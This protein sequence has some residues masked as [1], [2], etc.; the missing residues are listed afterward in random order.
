MIENFKENIITKDIFDEVERKDPYYTGRWK[1]Y[2]E[3]IDILKELDDVHNVLEFGPYILP[4]VRGSDIMDLT[5][6]NKKKYPFEIGKFMVH[7][8]AAV[9][10]P[11]KDKEYDL[12]IACQVME[13]FGMKGQQV[14]FF[15][16]LE[17]ICKKAIISLPY[18]W[19]RPF[20]RDHHMIDKNVI[21][22]WSNNRKPVFEM[23]TGENPRNLRIIQIYDFENESS[24]SNVEKISFK[25][26]VY[27]S[28]KKDD[29]I[30]KLSE[31]NEKLKDNKLKLSEEND[32]LKDNGIRLS[33]ENAMLKED[34]QTLSEENEKLKDDE[35]KLSEENKVLKDNKIKLS[36]ENAV[37]K[38]YKVRLSE[39]N[40][41]LK[42]NKIKLSEENA[43]LNDY[44]VRLSEE[45][46][47]LKYNRIKL[48]EEN[49]ALNDHKLRLSEENKVL[50]DNK[51]KLSEENA[52]L[53][54]KKQILSEENAI[55]KEDKEML[56]NEK[57]QIIDEISIMKSSKSWKVT[58]PLRV[59]KSKFK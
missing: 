2:S 54:N 29:L 32:R 10:L 44:K 14:R 52:K 22:Y 18:K 11:I 4:F 28:K 42:D 49:A 48:Y 57:M 26:Y 35:L 12:V 45:N 41:V 9:P 56:K 34:N 19:F 7:N 40:K 50:K 21:K 5:D 27:E 30:K 47:D 58:K 31:E 13:H 59:L 39:E 33:E 46:K 36:E 38:D 1:Y 43:V 6:D 51:I 8:C 16:E 55:L 17:R 15:N 37:L 3:I 53:K 24:I 23:I 20:L 25:G